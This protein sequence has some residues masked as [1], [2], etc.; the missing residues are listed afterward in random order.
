MG[1]KI[2]LGFFMTICKLNWKKNLQISHYIL[3]GSKQYKKLFNC[4]KNIISFT[5][6][7][8]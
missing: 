8:G 6:K 2:I 4:K 7:F 5:A 3:V 1:K